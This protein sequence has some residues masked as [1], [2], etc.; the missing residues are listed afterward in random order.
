MKRG[1]ADRRAGELKRQERGATAVFVAATLFLLMGFAALAVDTGIV[2]SDRRQQQSAADGGAL[3]A[4]LFAKTT[5]TSTNATCIP[6]SGTDFAACRG[7]EEAIAVVNGTLPDRYSDAAWLLCADPN[8]P[9]E[10]TEGST[11]SPCITYTANFQKVRVVLPGTDVDTSFAAVIGITSVRVGA[12][13]HAGFS[14]NSSADVLPWALGPSSAASNYT[15]LMANTAA[16]LDIDPCNGPAQGNFGKL[17]LSL[18][19]NGDIITHKRCGNA[20]PAVKMAVNL[21]VGSDHPLEIEADSGGTVH[22]YDNCNLITN[23]V[24]QVRTITGNSSG[25]IKDGLYNGV[26]ETT[27]G[28][29]GRLMCKD[30]TS[31]EEFGGFDS[32]T[33]VAVGNQFPE[34]VDHT[35]L[36]TFIDPNVTELPPGKKDRCDDVDTSLEMLT[37]LEAWRKYGPPHTVSLFTTALEKSPRFA[38]IPILETEPTLGVG[39][40]YIGDFRPI[41]LDTAYLGCSGQG[42]FIVH[43]PGIP[44]SGEC[45]RTLLSSTESCGWTDTKNRPFVALTS[46]MLTIDMLPSAIRENFPSRPGT[47]TSNL[48]L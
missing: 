6:L 25:A 22:D 19:G 45:P 41:Y 47:L 35:P 13:A 26:G 14:L 20:Q 21:I 11:I 16:K 32:L 39:D 7:A 5:L 8:K 24:D 1:F 38:A 36:W 23:P 18:Y 10:F 46:Y 31:P 48:V 29:E 15:C 4:I 27:P 3:A 33:C 30:G 9:A 37:C 17:D 28:Y 42:C 12:T 40:Y 34:D 44:D 43:T 2:F